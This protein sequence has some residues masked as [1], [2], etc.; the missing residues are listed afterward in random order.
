MLTASWMTT[1]STGAWGATYLMRALRNVWYDTLNS[2]ARR[3]SGFDITVGLVGMVPALVDIASLG[4][5]RQLARLSR[6]QAPADLFIAVTG[7]VA[8]D[9]TMRGHGTHAG[10]LP[11]RRR[12]AFGVERFWASCG[13]LRPYAD[14]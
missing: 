8:E 5:V 10:P 4:G 7:T 9:G 1:T 2:G 14:R 11:L 3:R 6:V 13:G 12:L